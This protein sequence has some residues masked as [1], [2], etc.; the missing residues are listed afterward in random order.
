M[1]V[2]K[3]AI[4]T[5]VIILS[6]IS[7]CF[8]QDDPPEKK[9]DREILLVGN[10][11]ETK[12]Q[13]SYPVIDAMIDQ[14]KDRDDHSTVLFLG[15][16][17][18]R[19]ILPEGAKDVDRYLE[20]EVY[21]K[22]L[23]ELKETGSDFYVLPGPVEWFFSK[24]NNHVTIRNVEKL[25]ELLFK[26]SVFFPDHGCPGPAEVEIDDQ[27][28]L[29]FI[30]TQWWL[31]LENE[32][33]DFENLEC[34]VQ[35][36]G[37][38]LIQLNDALIRNEGKHILV[39]GYHPILS[40][41]VHNGYLPGYI[42]AT[43]PVLGS[44]Y[45]LYRNFI[46]QVNDFANPT[47][48]NMIKGLQSILKSHENVIYVSSHE[49]SQQ[50]IRSENLHQLISGSSVKSKHVK[51]LA[52]QFT[53][54]RLGFM[55]LKFYGNGEV[56][57]EVFGVN[58]SAQAEKIY[59]NLLYTLERKKEQVE[60]NRNMDFK[61]LTIDT[62][63]SAA[64]FTEREKPGI[65]GINYRKEWSQ[66]IKDIPYID[67]E[68][69]KG[70]LKPVSRG[71][72]MQTK[73]L[74]LEN[75]RGQEYVLRSIEKFPEAAIP[76]ELRKT[77]VSDLVKDFISS[78]HPYGALVIPP[79]ADAANIYHTNPKLVYLPD[80]PALGVYREEYGHGLYLFEERPMDKFGDLES[81]GE[82]E[83]IVSTDDVIETILDDNESYVDQKQVLKSR[84]FDIW[85]GD[86]DRHADQ[87]RWAEFEGKGK[88]KFYHAIPRDR[89]QAFFYND[90]LL[91]KYG[92]RQPS[93]AK[94]QGFDY[95]IRDIRGM[96]YNARHFDRM[97]LTEQD[98]GD[99]EKTTEYLQE[100]LTDSLIE[101]AI[102]ILPEEIYQHS[103]DKIIGK[104]KR[105]RDDLGFYARE[106][107]EFL[108]RTVSVK[109]SN[110]KEMFDVERLS[111]E[112]TRV[113]VWDPKQKSEKHDRKMYDRVFR[114]DV[115]DE[116]RLYGMGDD[117]RFSLSGNVNKGIK[118]RVIGGTGKDELEDLSK[119]RGCSRKTIVYD[120]VGGMKING[121]R[122]LKL[123]LSNEPGVNIFNREEF[124]Y[125]F[126]TPLGYIDISPDDG[127][128]FTG[129]VKFFTYGFRKYPYRNMQLY[130]LRYSPFVNSFKFKY[131]G[132][133][134]GLI[135]KW[136]FNITGDFKYPRYTDYFYGLGNETNLDEEKRESEYYHFQYASMD[137][138]PLIVRPFNQ[139]TQFLKA[140]PIL[141]SYRLNDAANIERKYLEDFPESDLDDFKFFTGIRAGYIL[142]SRDSKTFPRHGLFWST[143][144]SRT[145]EVK[146]DS[147][148]FNS[149][150]TDLSVYQ[151]TGGSLNTVFAARVGGTVV[152]GNYQFYQ[153]ADLGGRTNLRGHRRMRFSG[154]K[155]LYLNLEARLRL[156]QFNM[157]LFPGSFGLFG[158]FDTGRVWYENIE[159]VDPTAV[160]GKS[161]IWHAGY[162]GG[163][164]IAPLK[165]FVFTADL[166]TSTTDQR[167]LV[168][169]KYGF[170][171]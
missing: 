136:D 47:Y 86:W 99:W 124:Q 78:S 156:F 51:E 58:K 29:I 111:D 24:N 45:Y 43:P 134:I 10:T 23:E 56:W 151:S 61:R 95:T 71:G 12:L 141:Y 168:N 64:Y 144:L 162:G 77:I 6:I 148:R 166:S 38:L 83:D 27:T 1:K 9:I 126:Y 57:L 2:K 164:W 81:F 146:N 89:D 65:M 19:N 69:A 165:K 48:S 75:E 40:Y 112:E 94:F 32:G 7:Y 131:E 149:V 167:I 41:G 137:I 67:L 49:L 127:I 28:V 91:I 63:A 118:I 100:N 163:L 123:N 73:S 132:D 142:D 39:T 107:Y 42:H 160:S 37:D 15:N 101:S 52:G 30:D 25:I 11:G 97:F 88:N 139:R 50:Y 114:T 153:S 138:R 8:P 145:F 161:D 135:G 55:K 128:F 157:P 109:G 44:I 87:W 26:G 92:T 84:L 158:F 110:E 103:G 4:L 170:F 3:A 85:I 129:E 96:N 159:G 33:L 133:F 54:E 22:K 74:R 21:Y 105:R 125:D 20:G 93:L 14:L 70:G 72:G 169:V 59:E 17:F 150:E 104:L 116:I 121:G 76:S 60:E 130:S 53:S 80:D 16:L 34:E 119:V 35:S 79:L 106:Y 68:T 82:P 115:T 62:L 117:D 90:G 46:G 140:G 13:D 66:V 120:N 155:S 108:S 36:P 18:P 154:D 98:W 102:H 147:I 113:R 171:F 152:D 31:N 122:E 143:W 5:I